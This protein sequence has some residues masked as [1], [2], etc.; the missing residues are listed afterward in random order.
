MSHPTPAAE[1]AT[2]Q[3]ALVSLA[4]EAMTKA[5]A[6]RL[7]GL[8]PAGT[9][10]QAASLTEAAGANPEARIVLALPDP[11]EAVAAR[12]ATQKAESGQMALGAWIAEMAPVLEA[13]RSLRRRLWLIDARAM[14]DGRPQDL[15]PA[16]DAENLPKGAPIAPPADPIYLALAEMLIRADAQ[17]T[18]LAAEIA[19]LRRGPGGSPID[20]D[21]ACA[22]LNDLQRR[23]LESG[24]LRDT[25]VLSQAELEGKAEA[26][27][28][29]QR[30]VASHESLKAEVERLRAALAESQSLNEELGVLRERLALLQAELEEK[31]EA[32]AMAQQL[33]A[34]HESLKAE[35]EQSRAGL[36]DRPQPELEVGLLR[37]TLALVQDE[38]EASVRALSEARQDRAAHDVLKARFAALE[39]GMADSAERADLHG[40]VLGAELLKMKDILLAERAGFAQDRQEAQNSIATLQH[41]VQTEQAEL[42]AARAE[43]AALQGQ[44]Q[45]ARNEVDLLL[46]ST[47]WQVTAPLRAVKRRLAGS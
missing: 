13:T 40:Q 26:L 15:T 22:A 37:K 36:A 30:L 18:R 33:A 34:S 9:I 16:S 20:L 4:P 38:L 17:A 10:T 25:L 41:Q 21:L 43:L 42:V 1:P 19:A 46:A 8:F 39:R 29:A 32:L 6:H 44:V 24:I 23:K 7:A 3:I 47:S 14:A 27:A 45:A 35:V 28:M 11:V 5:V 12:L 2:L 31:S